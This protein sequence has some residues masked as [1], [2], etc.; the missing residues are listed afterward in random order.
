MITTQKQKGLRAEPAY[1]KLYV[2]HLDGEL[3]FI[4][5]FKGPAVY[6]ELA[7]QL[8]KD[9][10]GR[11]TASQ[12]SSLIH[13]AW[14]TQ[15]ESPNEQFSKEIISLLKSNWLACFT[16]IHYVP[17]EGAYIQ[18]FPEIRDGRVFMEKSELV[19][20]LEANDPSVRF[21]PF[22]YQISEQSTSELE[23]NPFV[24]RLAG[25]EGAQ[26][27]AEVSGNYKYKPYVFSFD[28]VSNPVTTLSALFA[29]W[30]HG[31]FGLGV[32]GDVR[33]GGGASCAF[34]VFPKT[35]EGGSQ[36]FS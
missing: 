15:K 28:N 33:G 1:T 27:L 24:I 12:N 25:E 22:G 35:A 11:P 17:N 2:P 32:S 13:S 26:K 31:C 9:S 14:E 10:L 7:N 3:T 34:G 8:D 16:G 6:A 5:P 19:R 30:G 23:K 21:V 29:Y 36:N 20:K 4:H 18:D